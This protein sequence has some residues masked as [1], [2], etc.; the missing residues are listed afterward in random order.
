MMFGD[1]EE[2]IARRKGRGSENGEDKGSERG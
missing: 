1:M 2:S